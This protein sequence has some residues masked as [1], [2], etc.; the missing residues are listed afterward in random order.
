M[1]LLEIKMPSDPNDA[2]IFYK[3]ND[4][5][6][7]WHFHQEYELVL[8]TKGRGK[9]M[10]GDHIARFKENDLVFMGSKTPHEHLCDPEYYDEKEGFRGEGLVIQF[11]HDFLGEK[12]F[13]LQENH[14]LKR[15]LQDSSR[16]FEI[17]GRS[18]QKI[19]A[20]MLK[21]QEMNSTD[22]LYAL[23]SIF[24]IF[25]SVKEVKTLSSPAYM[26]TFLHYDNQPMQ[27][28]MQHIMQNYQNEIALQD[29]LEIAHMSN[30]TFYEA[31][32]RSFKMSFKSYLL[33]L[34]VGYACKLLT[35]ESYSIAEIAYSCGFGNLSNFNRQFKKIKGAT[36]SRYLKELHP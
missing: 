24:H 23:F 21:M 13:E 17:K 31:F 18:K 30:T 16:G 7:K 19:I 12:F 33:N 8:I 6:P 28:V 2:F 35:Q 15:F 22:R 1:K 27:Q 5:F 34:R 14:Q 32:K 20:M 11:T 36:P 3:E 10:V 4:P 25:M 26:E 9:R 29:L